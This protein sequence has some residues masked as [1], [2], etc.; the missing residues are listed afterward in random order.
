MAEY[1]DYY[2]LSEFDEKIE[3][4]KDC[5]R[6]SIK[7]ETQELIIKLQE[8]NEKLKDVKNNWESIQHEYENKTKE[9]QK[10]IS[11]AKAF[12]ARMRLKEL[13]EFCGMNMVLY[14]PGYD[15]VYKPKC[16]KCDDDRNVHFKSPSGRDC[17]ERCSCAEKFKKYSPKPY[18]CT[19]FRVDEHINSERKYPMLM[20]FRPYD[21]NNSYDGYEASYLCEF[22]Y[23]GEAFE[24]VEENERRPFFRDKEQCQKYCNYLN[25]KN[26]ITDDMTI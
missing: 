25:N 23:S 16:K 1:E 3:E 7:E 20:W 18:Y 12:A 21:N 4:F 15:Y 11:N 5:L 14:Y 26:G 19:E 10:E 13:F 17:K 6:K 2:E 8:E 9:L 24:F 22:V